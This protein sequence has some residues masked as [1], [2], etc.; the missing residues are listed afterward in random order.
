MQAKWQKTGLKSPICITWEVTSKCNLNCQHCLSASMDLSARDLS[1]AEAKALIDHLVEIDVFYINMG[2]GE[3]FFRED[4]LDVLNYTD[5]KN[6]PV[7]LSTNGTLVTEEIAVFLSKIREISIQVSLDGSYPQIND[8]IR[9]KGSFAGA[10]RAIELLISRGIETSINFVVTNVNFHDLEDCYQ[11]SRRY[12]A[13]FRVSRLRPSGLAR[14]VYENYHLTTE[15]NKQLY[16]WLKNHPD[17]STGDSF[18]FLSALGKPFARQNTCGA[19]LMTCSIAPNGD[20]YPCA[21]LMDEQ[22]AGNVRQQSL[23]EIWVHSELFQRL[24]E[25][26]L[27]ECQSCEHISSCGGGCPAVSAYYHNNLYKKDPECL[28]FANRVC[29][30]NVV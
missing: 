20:V 8:R 3:P 7:Q 26:E 15:Q 24:R 17:V 5:Q 19:A 25:R 9:G 1:F 27:E 13:A 11:L 28:R 23:R 12:G 22:K 10:V 2:G 16:G 6:M 29:G 4:I 30:S 21:F 18:F 14:S